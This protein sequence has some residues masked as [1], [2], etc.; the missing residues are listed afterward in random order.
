MVYF[1]TLKVTQIRL[2]AQNR[3]GKLQPTGEPRETLKTGLRAA[4]VYTCIGEGN[5]FNRTPLFIYSKLR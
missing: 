5:E 4:F 1:M 2:T 3:A